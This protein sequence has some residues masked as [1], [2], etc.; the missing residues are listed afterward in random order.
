MV[1]ES[2]LTSVWRLCSSFLVYTIVLI[3]STTLCI[4]SL[5]YYLME[6]CAAACCCLFFSTSHSTVEYSQLWNSWAVSS[7]FF[8]QNNWLYLCIIYNLIHILAF[9]HI[10]VIRWD[11]KNWKITPIIIR[12]KTEW[13]RHQENKKLALASQ[14]Q[15]Y[16]IL[17]N[18][19]HAH[20]VFV[21]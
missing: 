4:S 14:L 11:L 6:H 20:F 16:Q 18:N 10:L 13:Y 21:I 3:V 5:A 1:L 2:I 7:T 12:S 17:T 9:S 19:D 8:Y 15:T